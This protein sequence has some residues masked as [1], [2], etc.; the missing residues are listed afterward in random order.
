ML[1][2]LLVTIEEMLVTA[3]LLFIPDINNRSQLSELTEISWLIMGFCCASRDPFCWT[4]I[5]TLDYV[6]MRPVTYI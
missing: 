6:Q 2:L 5:E 1:C 4:C 3:G